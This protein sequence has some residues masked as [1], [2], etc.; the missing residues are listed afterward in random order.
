M[1]KGPSDSMGDGAV[2]D[3]NLTYQSDP[4]DENDLMNI[5]SA[6]SA[7]EDLIK[8]SRGQRQRMDGK[9]AYLTR[10][11]DTSFKE[12]ESLKQEVDE[13]ELKLKDDSLETLQRQADEVEKQWEALME[14]TKG[15]ESDGLL[16]DL[17]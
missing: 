4:L 14:R 7:I 8:E 17:A 13:L 1:D 15:W 12:M 6:L 16:S 11:V 10:E 2:G 5:M 3:I 9:L